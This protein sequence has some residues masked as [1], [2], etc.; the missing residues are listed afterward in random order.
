MEKQN[1]VKKLN[2]TMKED[3]LKRAD[4]YAS[5]NGMTRSGLLTLALTT[6]LNA[7]EAMPSVNKLL[8]GFAAMQDELFKGVI[9]P[10]EAKNRLE[11]VQKTYDQLQSI[12]IM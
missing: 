1:N 6:Y 8:N 10:E 2:I 12:K 11:S 3:L 7:K 4:E 9:T 5:E